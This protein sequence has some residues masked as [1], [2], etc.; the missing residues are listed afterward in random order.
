MMEANYPRLWYHLR[1]LSHLERICHTLHP[2]VDMNL[3]AYVILLCFTR[4][5]WTIWPE[6]ILLLSFSRRSWAFWLEYVILLSASLTVV[7]P[8]GHN[9]IFICFTRRSW[10][11]W[12]EDV[13]FLNVLYGG[14]ALQPVYVILLLVTVTSGYLP[15][16][17]SFSSV[18]Q[19]VVT[20]TRHL[21]KD[22]QFH[23]LKNSQII[24]LPFLFSLCFFCPPPFFSVSIKVLASMRALVRDWSL[25]HQKKKKRF[26]FHS[27]QEQDLLARIYYLYNFLHLSWKLSCCIDWEM[28]SHTF[29]SWWWDGWPFMLCWWRDGWPFM[30]C[31]WWHD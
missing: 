19:V 17:L 22:R 16:S 31:W 6:Y 29:L 2:Q 4:S 12:L 27:E 26:V 8:S 3:L 20:A 18:Y 21:L 11:I 13:I 5:G 10:S 9:V 1:G 30:L 28:G 23:L 15:T 7:G 24:H 14:W 25:R